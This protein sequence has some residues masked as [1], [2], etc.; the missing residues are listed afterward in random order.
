MLHNKNR[1]YNCFQHQKFETAHK[2]PANLT[3]ALNDEADESETLP[4][5][6]VKNAGKKVHKRYAAEPPAPAPP[7]KNI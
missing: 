6:P 4:I 5:K 3:F 1:F 2:I 7:G